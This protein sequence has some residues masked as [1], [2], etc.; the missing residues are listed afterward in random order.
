MSK[1]IATVLRDASKCL[2]QYD[3]GSAL[4]MYREV[5]TRE[6][7]NAAG[8]MGLAMVLNRSGRPADALQLLNR[9]L[10]SV[11]RSKA[12]L[13]VLQQAAILAQIGLSQQELGQL[14]AALA[15]YR[16]AAQLVP[17]ADLERRMQ[18]IE[19]LLNSP[20]PVQHLILHAR[21]QKTG[22]KWEEAAQ[23]YMAALRLQPDNADALHELAVV[24]QELGSYDQALPLMQKAIILAPDRPEFFNDLGI[25][26]QHRADFDKAI[27]FHKRAIRLS[28]SFVFAH[29]NLGVAYKRLGLHDQSL[30]AYRQALEIDPESCEAHNNLGNLLRVMGQLPL[31]RRHLELALRIRPGYGD[32][33]A[34]LEAVLLALAQQKKKPSTKDSVHPTSKETGKGLR[35]SVKKPSAKK[36]VAKKVTTKSSIG[37][38]T[39]AKKATSK[40]TSPAKKPLTK[41]TGK[42]TPKGLIGKKTAKAL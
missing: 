21:R 3:L 38:K 4:Q 22:R 7:D 19:P 33:K 30:L 36:L 9:I 39:V 14:D 41:A 37:T 35:G 8:A 40:T 1:S 18:Q 15:S 34:N 28:P 12:K 26:F 17:S 2:E 31:A 10:A 23:T 6:P 42:S 27:S 24:M 32:A 16:Q 5:L 13:P 29:I 11:S 25:L 20:M